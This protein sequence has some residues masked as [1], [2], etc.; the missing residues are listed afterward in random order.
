MVQL[1]VTHP[2]TDSIHL[3]VCSHLNSC[4]GHVESEIFFGPKTGRWGGVGGE[5]IQRMCVWIGVIV[6][7]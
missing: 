5:I 2:L 3:C 6:A 4:V 1:C 7:V